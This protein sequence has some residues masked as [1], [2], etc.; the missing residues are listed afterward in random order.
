VLD[1]Y[2]ENDLPP[3]LKHA[4]ERAI[5]LKGNAGAKQASVPKADHFYNN[6]EAE[7]VKAVKDF[8]DQTLP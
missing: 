4:K 7:M 6:H 1:L 8:L 2:G 5:S 3:V